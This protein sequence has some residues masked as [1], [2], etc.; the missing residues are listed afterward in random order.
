MHLL[1]SLIS[2]RC[3]GL[4]LGRVGKRNHLAV[5]VLAVMGVHRRKL[6]T[7]WQ[8]LD[9]CGETSESWWK[10]GSRKSLASDLA[11][12]PN[13]KGFVVRYDSIWFMYVH[14]PCEPMSSRR[15]TRNTLLHLFSGSN[16]VCQVADTALAC[17]NQIRVQTRRVEWHATRDVKASRR[18]RS[19]PCLPQNSLRVIKGI[20]LKTC[21][22]ELIFSIFLWQIALLKSKQ[23]S[24][25]FQ[26]ARTAI[27]HIH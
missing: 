14:A 24:N 13:G 22:S 1:S 26:F 19:S 12:S 7:D 3:W 16:L 25:G 11:R 17:T 5:I 4:L 23:V 20:E 15:Q 18:V 2:P 10:L 27:G 9:H 21:F 6:H 8:V